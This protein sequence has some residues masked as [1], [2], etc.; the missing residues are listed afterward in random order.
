MIIVTGQGR[1]G[2]A[3]GK[4]H[5]T[6]NFSFFNLVWR[7]WARQTRLKKREEITFCPLPGAALSPRLPPGCHLIVLTGLQFGSL[8]SRFRRTI[9]FSDRISF[10]AKPVTF[11]KPEQAHSGAARLRNPQDYHATGRFEAFQAGE[12]EREF[13][14]LL[15]F[16]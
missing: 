5:P 11:H 2:P 15:K 12:A 13:R 1:R 3:P 6:P 16:N 9:E 7:A 4:R 8:R 10:R 14:E